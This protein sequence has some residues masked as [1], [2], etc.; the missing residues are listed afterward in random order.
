MPFMESSQL[1]EHTVSQDNVRED[2]GAGR[3]F[4][5]QGGEHARTFADEA[6]EKINVSMYARS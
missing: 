4:E 3:E 5:A 1:L 6:K 2:T